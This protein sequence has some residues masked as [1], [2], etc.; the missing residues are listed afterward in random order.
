MGTTSRAAQAFK[1]GPDGRPVVIRDANGR[2]AGFET[3]SFEVPTLLGPRRILIST[4][5]LASDLN[6]AGV[7]AISS[8]S[9]SGGPSTV[10]AGR[11][12]L[13]PYCVEIQ[14]RAPS[15]AASDLLRALLPR[16][17]EEGFI[18]D[19]SLGA[20]NAV[21]GQTGGKV[22]NSRLCLYFQP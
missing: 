8:Q 2:P 12:G 3:E 7:Q 18:A 14:L 19:F 22:D 9:P 15:A 17:R 10:L 20:A 11:L 1:L 6:V 13:P 4:R 21:T 5:V 16:V